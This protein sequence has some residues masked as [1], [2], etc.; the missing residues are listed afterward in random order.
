[1]NK[2]LQKAHHAE[3][4]ALK[5]WFAMKPDDDAAEVQRAAYELRLAMQ[6]VDKLKDEENEK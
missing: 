1:M 6:A 4:T 3:H 2:A 5:R